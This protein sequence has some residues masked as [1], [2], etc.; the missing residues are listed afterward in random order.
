MNINK[1]VLR[2]TISAK[3][4]IAFAVLTV[5]PLVVV[6]AVVVPMAV[7]Q[8]RRNAAG[9]LENELELMRVRVSGSIREAEQHLA[10][11]V[12]AA[13]L[14]LLSDFNAE[15]AV[16]AQSM[17]TTFLRSDSSAI[18]SVKA[19]NSVGTIAFQVTQ[20]RDLVTA[21]AT[22]LCGVTAYAVCGNGGVGAYVL[23]AAL[24][25]LRGRREE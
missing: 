2:L 9:D 8:L 25:A 16:Q 20:A 17:A 19:F 10:F 18:L 13:I 23:I 6:A 7:G 11:M 21:E 3:L 24:L 5:L 4:T 15:S 12:D 22:A 14:P 1:L